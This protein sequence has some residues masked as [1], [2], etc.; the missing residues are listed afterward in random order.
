M[1]QA[2]QTP[3]AP[4]VTER[5]Q[6][7]AFW[8]Q[9]AAQYDVEPGPINLEYGYF[10]RMTRKALRNY[11]ENLAYVNRSNS[12]Y[13][14]Q[15]FDSVDSEVI[16]AQLASLVGAATHEIAITRCASEGLQSLI[17]NYNE[18]RP[19]DQLLISDLDYMS[20]QTAMRWLAKARGIELIEIQHAHPA[21]YDAVLDAYRQAFENNPRLKLM[22]LTHVTHRTGL[23]MPVQAIAALA[24][25]HGVDV[26]LDGAHALGQMDFKVSELGV[27]FAGYN[28]QKW[29]GAPLSLGF[30][31]VA[32]DRLLSV[33]PDMGDGRYPL[34][35]LLS[36][37]P[38]GTPN[39]P[40]LMTLPTVFEEHLAVGG[41]AVKGARLNYLRELW[42]KPAREIPGIEVL[43]PDDPRLCCGISA[44]RF[45]LHADQDV[46]IERLLREHGLFTVARDGSACGPC[47]RVTPGF[48]TSAAD[49]AQLVTALRALA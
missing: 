11:E 19:G 33:D 3:E 45:T 8:Q 37:V 4:S 17:R 30:I 29:I 43:T 23:V 13:V 10:G 48:T 1:A 15:Q 44:F 28:L 40:A 12:V 42:V 27:A 16:R 20:V 9:V 34:D 49:V 35:E 39:I 32:E 18:L 2:A 21:S 25:E 46:M 38:Y 31:F 5:A 41:S 14:R 22:A 47:I 6:D 26:I 36:R 24:R 7:E